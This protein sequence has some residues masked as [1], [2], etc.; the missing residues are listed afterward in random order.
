MSQVAHP[1]EPAPTLAADLCYPDPPTI[2][3]RALAIRIRSALP[4]TKLVW[5]GPS[6]LL[7]RHERPD[8]T[9]AYRPDPAD[10]LGLPPEQSPFTEHDTYRS[11]LLLCSVA[12]APDRTAGERD[13]SQSWQWP[14]A[15]ATLERCRHLVTITQLVG[16]G[17]DSTERVHAFRAVLDA[18]IATVRP[19]ATWWPASQQALPPGALVAHPLTGV[20]NVRQFRSVHDPRVTMTDTLGLHALGLPDI[21]CQSRNL[22]PDRLSDLLFELAEYV[23]KHGDVLRPGSPVPGLS[24]DQQFVPNRAAA[25]VPPVRPVIDLDPG[26]GYGV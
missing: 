4:G 24:A 10:I 20:V 9:T 15:G 8:P 16:R 14:D 1:P 5:A 17:R 21:Q 2:N 22:D 18:I 3:A 7:L 23:Y 11:D 26:P 6:N 13:L 12:F 25:T 19:L